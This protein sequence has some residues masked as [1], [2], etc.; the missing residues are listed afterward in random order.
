[1]RISDWSSDVCSSDL[2]LQ[3]R[4]D[5]VEVHRLQRVGDA[6]I[7]GDGVPE[8]D[9]EADVLI[10]LLE[11]EGHEGGVGGDD[12]VGGLCRRAGQHRGGE[13]GGYQEFAPISHVSSSLFAA[14]QLWRPLDANLHGFLQIVAMKICK[15]VRM[16]S[17]RRWRPRAAR[18]SAESADFPR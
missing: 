2:G 11:L 10:A 12:K 3:R 16:R 5:A 9:V 18:Q 8:V 1:M 7:L 17:R 13:A 6:D 4:D 15:C 14:A